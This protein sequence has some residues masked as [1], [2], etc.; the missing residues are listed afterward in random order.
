MCRGF[1]QNHLTRGDN[2]YYSSVL[3]N[4]SFLRKSASYTVFHCAVVII[5]I[6][7]Y[8]LVL[9]NA[10]VRYAFT[11]FILAQMRLPLPAPPSQLV[12]PLP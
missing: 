9:L 8:A 3:L 11:D 7:P 6:P 4:L 5:H 12:R 1:I 2:H 10:Q